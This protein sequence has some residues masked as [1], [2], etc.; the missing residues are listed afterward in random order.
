MKM[1]DV[2]D[3][4]GL[5]DLKNEIRNLRKADHPN[6]VKLIDEKKTVDHHYLYFEY[7]NGGTLNDLKLISNTL[8]EGVVRNIGL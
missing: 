6:I 8:S 5:E 2:R 4:G 3:K 7:C 1:Q